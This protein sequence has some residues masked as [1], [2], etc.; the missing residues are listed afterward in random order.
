M[1]IFLSCIGVAIHA[2]RCVCRVCRGKAGPSQLTDVAY[3]T[4]TVPVIRW[5]INTGKYE[6]TVISK[7]FLQPGE[8]STFVKR[9]TKS[10]CRR[11]DAIYLDSIDM[12]TSDQLQKCFNSIYT[13]F[14]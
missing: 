11:C 1:A 7:D 2:D 13:D 12:D 6:Q 5:A 14:N 9:R 8:E 4:Y 3:L 10:K